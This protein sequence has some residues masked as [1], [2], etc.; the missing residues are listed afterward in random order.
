MRRGA[1]AIVAT[2]LALGLLPVGASACSVTQKSDGTKLGPIPTAAI[3][4]DLPHMTIADWTKDS[5]LIVAGAVVRVDEP[6][7]NSANGKRWSPHDEGSEALVYQTFYV[8]V[9]EALKGT[10][11]WE[12]PVA[13]RAWW[14]SASGAGPVRVG[15]M[16]VAFG[17][18][19]PGR[20]G[21]QGVYQ[22]ADAYWLTSEGNSLWIK[23]GRSYENQGIVKDQAERL[24]TL[25][26][27]EA[28]IR[29]AGG[30]GKTVPTSETERP[31]LRVEWS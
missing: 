2:V 27:L 15:D 25:N 26:E 23:Q 22:P 20:Y 16:V 30:P 5:D 29:E 11:K 1:L 12:E 24:V 18:L 13:F 19:S 6:R 28:R 17:Q 4:W 21:S 14:N 8:Q 31:V 7:W 9:E 3:E 10:P